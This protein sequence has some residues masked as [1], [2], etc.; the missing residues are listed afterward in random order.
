MKSRRLS[1]VMHILIVASVFLFS[2]CGIP[3]YIE[4][5]IDISRID[6]SDY[7]EF[8]LKYES[9]NSGYLNGESIGL[10]LFYYV[11]SGSALGSQTSYINTW[12]K[13][14][15]RISERDGVVLNVKNVGT[16]LKTIKGT[17]DQEFDLYIFDKES[18]FVDAPS[19]NYKLI[20]SAG[21]INLK[22][23]LSYIESNKILLEVFENSI[24]IASK[25]LYIDSDINLDPNDSICVYA[26]VSVQSNNY[27]NLYWS[28]IYYEGALRTE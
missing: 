28:N 2:A 24:L 6:S 1:S 5:K 11:E 22:F 4:P 25:F 17:N 7:V 19:Y 8:N 21:P 26:A 12:F 18:T 10:A 14:D 13:N 9:E 27:S 16:P 15:V 3:T 23:R 20:D